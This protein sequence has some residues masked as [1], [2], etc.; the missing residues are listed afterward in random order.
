MLS[1]HIPLCV[2]GSLGKEVGIGG[3]VSELPPVI[4]V[5]GEVLAHVHTA[6]HRLSWKTASAALRRVI[7][8]MTVG[9]DQLF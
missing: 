5:P 9:V 4:V 6:L 8:V 2:G 3:W 7:A 1:H